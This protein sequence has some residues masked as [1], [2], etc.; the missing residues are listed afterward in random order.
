MALPGSIRIVSGGVI[1]DEELTAL[2]LGADPDQ[3]I[4][5][6]AV[7]LAQYLASIHETGES[8]PQ[9]QVGLLPSWYMAPVVSR[10]V[11]RI[12]QLIV[13]VV[14]ATFVAIEA[15]GLCSTYGQLFFH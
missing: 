5:P 7:P 10:R 14:I 4:D 1:S 12:P 8:D 13:L 15:A 11:G 6:A 3:G 9:G 2:A